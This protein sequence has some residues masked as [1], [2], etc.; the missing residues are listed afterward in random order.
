MNKKLFRLSLFL[1]SSLLL[2]C[3]EWESN[4]ATGNK[5]QVLHF[6]N[7]TEPSGLDPQTVTGVPESNILNSLLEGLV[8][9]HPKD[10]RIIP[11]VAKKWELSDN[12]LEYTFH[13]RR[14]AKWSNGDTVTAH[15]FVYSWQRILSP[16]LAAEYAYM[17]Y[18]LENA[19]AFNRGQISDF[20]KVGVK[21]L[22]NFTLKVKLRSPTPFFLS[23]IGGHYSAYPVHKPTIEKFGSMTKRNST[24]T[25]QENF[26][27]N[28]AFYI[29]ERKLNR[30]LR[31]KK[32]PHYWDNRHVKLE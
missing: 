4:V 6:G 3:G 23:L 29:A 30:P 12:L 19:E 27:G 16:E 1:L 14:D 7:G 32:N 11:G 10:L 31:V 13:L 18:Y 2:S 24:W 8:A 25:R 15:D 9:V 17:L 26:V 28:G 5:N 21:A 22:D 20:S